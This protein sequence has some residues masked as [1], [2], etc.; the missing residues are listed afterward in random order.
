MKKQSRVFW[1]TAP[2]LLLDYLENAFD[3]MVAKLHGRSTLVLLL[4]QNQAL[5]AKRLHQR[6][7]WTK[8]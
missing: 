5:L 4:R 2:Q 8:T 7:S 1:N 3:P 6:L